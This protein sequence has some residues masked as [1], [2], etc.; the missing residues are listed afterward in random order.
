MSWT[1]FKGTLGLTNF[2]L[3]ELGCI[4]QFMCSL[5]VVMLGY[6]LYCPKWEILVILE[7]KIITA[8]PPQQNSC[9]DWGNPV[10]NI[11]EL[12]LFCAPSLREMLEVC[13]WL[14]GDGRWRQ[15][16]RLAFPVGLYFDIFTLFRENST[17][18]S[19]SAMKR[20]R[21]EHL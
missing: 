7:L 3:E 18:R 8:P 21:K 19:S 1:P 16:P 13:E 17:Q 4:F 6:Q 12:L 5:L 9:S 11:V 14:R 15:Q 2:F 20:T 10:A